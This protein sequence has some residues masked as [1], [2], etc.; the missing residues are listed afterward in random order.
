MKIFQPLRSDLSF[1]GITPYEKHAFNVKNMVA[2]FMS[3]I[4]ALIN[5]L[6]LLNETSTVN[7]YIESICATSALTVATILFS[8]LIW[9]TLPI[10][11]S[12]NYLE[13]TITKSKFK[14][15]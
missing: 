7:E 10:Y 12:M 8:I 1:V 14:H 2:L 3:S 9:R 6:H 11:S 4:G 15:A 5:Y 13:E